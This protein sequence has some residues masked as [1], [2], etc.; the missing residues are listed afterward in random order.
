MGYRV[1]SRSA[2]FKSRAPKR[3]CMRGESGDPG[4]GAGRSHFISTREGERRMDVT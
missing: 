3:W 4:G 1:N 2:S